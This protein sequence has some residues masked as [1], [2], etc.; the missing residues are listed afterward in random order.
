MFFGE[1]AILETTRRT[2]TVTATSEMTV[3]SMFGADF[4]KLATDSPEL[5]AV[6]T[7]AMAERRV[8]ET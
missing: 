4:A 6:I 2:A 8:T 7:A 1:A 5:H 3:G